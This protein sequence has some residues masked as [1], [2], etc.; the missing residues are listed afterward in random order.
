MDQPDA[1]SQRTQLGG[2]R[3]IDFDAI[4]RAFTTGTHS[5]G[6]VITGFQLVIEESSS[7]RLPMVGI[8]ES[9]GASP[10]DKVYD[11]SG[12]VS[13]TGYRV[14]LAPYGAVLDS[15]TTYFSLFIKEVELALLNRGRLGL[16]MRIQILR[17]GG[18]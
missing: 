2:E 3:P 9:D 5:R 18:L 7:S 10:G 1:P 16:M 17:L 12:N 15:N 11:L 14:F 13:S 8:Y 6:Y 4:A